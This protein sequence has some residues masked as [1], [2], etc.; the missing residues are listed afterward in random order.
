MPYLVKTKYDLQGFHSFPNRAGWQIEEDGLFHRTP[1]VTH[2][3]T[4]QDLSAFLQAWL[5]FGLLTEVLGLSEHIDID[6]FTFCNEY[7]DWVVH[8]KKLPA[9]IRTWSSSIQNHSGR[10]TGQ[11]LKAQLALDEAYLWISK[12][13]SVSSLEKKPIWNL[14]PMVSLSLMTLGET[15][16]HAKAGIIESSNVQMSGWF[17]S[18]CQGW[19]YSDKLL[20]TMR[21]DG[22]CPYFL[23]VLQGTLR[24]SAS[25]LLYAMH[26]SHPKELKLSHGLCTP[27]SCKA[28]NYGSYR[29]RHWLTEEMCQCTSIPVDIT[30]LTNILADGGCPLLTYN[31]GDQ[32]VDVVR[33]E[34]GTIY[35]IFSH[36]FADGF[37]NP[38]ENS[39]P[40]CRLDNFVDILGRLSNADQS[41]H[42]ATTMTAPSKSACFWIDT[43]AIPVKH[44]Y[45][46]LRRKAIKDMHLMYIDATYTVVLDAGLMTQNRGN[47]YA[48]TAMKIATSF[49]M[50]RLWTLQE[51]CLSRRLLFNFSDTLVDVDTLERAFKEDMISPI[52][53]AARSYFERML[54]NERAR[55]KER[56]RVLVDP[57]FLTS[58]WNAL[59][60]R[61][62]SVPEHETQAIATL[63]RLDTDPFDDTMFNNS[64]EAQPPESSLDRKMQ[65][66]LKLMNDASD[67]AIPAGLIF[68]AG[69]K[70]SDKGFSWAPRSWLNNREHRSRQLLTPQ[71]GAKLTSS[72]LE[73][74]YPGF[75]LHQTTSRELFKELQSDD[76]IVFPCDSSLREWIVAR[77]KHP[78][79][80]STD[81]QDDDELAIVTQA[82]PI[83]THIQTALLVKSVRRDGHTEHV[84]VLGHITL[85]AEASASRI[86]ELQTRFKDKLSYAVLGEALPKTQKWCVDGVDQIASGS[87]SDTKPWPFSFPWFSS[88]VSIISMYV[89]LF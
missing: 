60:W 52:P 13:C 49:W 61:N 42:T 55:I 15:L 81:L 29:D 10:A 67:Q 32:I 89:S 44:Q 38:E 84:Q 14:Q 33:K 46:E 75:R 24:K 26:L 37:G 7:G 6:D 18:A 51:A 68:S 3:N 4:E 39:L 34:Y 20:H 80:L 87:N 25:G 50:T 22:W 83:M 35:T 66:L 77:S 11:L 88:S 59:E 63:L 9:Y 73:V 53:R 48:E 40:S 43:L 86:L 56:R 85:R 79:I 47:S 71:P 1:G 17:E 62:T 2:H 5:F 21:N 72:G 28:R 65:T 27:H 82:I 19:G 74:M 64:F 58:L 8:T 16:S 41:L 45:S 57:A 78:L 36:V 69:S 31:K 70:L 76:G 30:K 54:G 12:Y 23:R